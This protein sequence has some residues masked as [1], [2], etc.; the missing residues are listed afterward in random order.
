MILPISSKIRLLNPGNVRSMSMIFRDKA[1]VYGKWIGAASGA[2]FDVTNPLNG[3]VI[4]KVPDMDANDTQAAIAA[5]HDA[6]AVWK[7]TTAKERSNLLRK[8]FDVMIKNQVS[9]FVNCQVDICN[10]IS[11]S[12]LQTF[13]NMLP[14]LKFVK[15]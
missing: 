7:E 12:T 9:T 2:T 14:S 15:V 8:W 4:A 10:R 1:F 6:F 3:A 5:A 13:K 11:K